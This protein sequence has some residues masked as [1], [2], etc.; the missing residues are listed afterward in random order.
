[1]AFGGGSKKGPKNDIN[2]TPLVDVCLVLLI[3]FM[4]ITPMLQR[5]KP[6]KLPSAHMIDKE[7]STDPLVVSITDHKEIYVESE[8][9]HPDAVEAKVAGILKADKDNTGGRK[10]LLKADEKLTVGDVRPLMNHLK[11]AGSQGVA[12]GV[13]E[14]KK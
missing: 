2:V 7:K 12:L 9:V 4:V 8:A 10:I 14:A 6:V 11:E 5:G 1:M 13:E 3:I